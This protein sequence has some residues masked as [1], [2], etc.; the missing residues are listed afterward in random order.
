MNIGIISYYVKSQSY[1][2]QDNEE[3]HRIDVSRHVVDNMVN[4]IDGRNDVDYV[5]GEELAEGLGE[6]FT[7]MGFGSIAEEAD[8]IVTVG[9]DGTVLR[10]VR[11]L[12]DLPI[13]G[14]NTGRVGF[15]A[16][17]NPGEVLEELDRVINGFEVE[18]R[19]RLTVEVNGE[20]V[21][22]ALNEA[23]VVAESRGKIMEFDLEHGG[24]LMES[25]RADGVVTATPTGSTAYSL[26]EGGPIVKPSLDAFLLTPLAPFRVGSSP[27]VL[28]SEKDIHVTPVRTDIPGRV[29]VDGVA[30]TKVGRGDVLRFSRAEKFARFVKTDKPFFEK[31]RERL[32]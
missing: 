9:G 20:Q 26:S 17:V 13:L 5:L 6:D 16:D 11:A 32:K 8:L 3:S 23:V 19:T 22:K 27:W 31:V 24:E 10:T 29:V 21:A 25:L 15:L 30:I 18:K 1:E 2:P 28:G 7:G 14:V 4:Y 12:E